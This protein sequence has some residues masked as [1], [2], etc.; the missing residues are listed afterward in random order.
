MNYEKDSRVKPHTYNVIQTFGINR[1]EHTDSNDMETRLDGLDPTN[2]Y[3]PPWNEE[4]K[5]QW[6]DEQDSKLKKM[7]KK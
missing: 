2:P 7:I 1:E 6:L 5:K 3:N 4:T